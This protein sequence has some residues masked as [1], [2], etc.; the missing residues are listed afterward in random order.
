MDAILKKGVLP[1]TSPLRLHCTRLQ[2]LTDKDDEGLQRP[3]RA[4]QC[5]LLPNLTCKRKARS[6]GR[7]MAKVSGWINFD[8]PVGEK[9][10]WWRLG[11]YEMQ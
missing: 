4:E 11:G 3:F 2:Y 7:A 6:H 5:K 8:L 1:I 10:S 9:C